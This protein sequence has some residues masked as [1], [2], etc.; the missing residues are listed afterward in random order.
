MAVTYG[1]E[2]RV[3][4]GN[5]A[6]TQHNRPFTGL[7][8][9]GSTFLS[10]FQVSESP[11]ALLDSVTF[12]DTPGV[13]SGDKQRLGR[14]YDFV[15]VCQWFAERADMILILFDAHKLDISD[16]LKD[17]INVIRPHEDKIKIVLNK[18]DQISSQEL[19]RVYGALMWSL[20]KTIYTPEVVR[21]YIGSFWM[22]KSPVGNGEQAALLE[23][24]QTDL[25][26][27]LHGLPKDSAI[28]K[29]NEMI[30]RA[31]QIRVHAI[32]LGQLRYQ[33]PS[34]WGKANKQNKMIA[35]MKEEMYKVQQEFQFPICDLPDP[36]QYQD[37]LRNMDISS[38]PKISTKYTDMLNE[39]ITSDL[40]NLLQAFV[41]IHNTLGQVP[42][43]PFDN[44]ALKP[45]TSAQSSYEKSAK[46]FYTLHPDAGK[47]SG[48]KAREVLE[49]SGLGSDELAKIWAEADEDQDGQ[50]TEAEFCKAMELLNLKSL[51]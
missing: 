34:F 40:P 35:N 14:S 24:E 3:I 1:E 43:N 27:H 30:K 23:A 2:E 31:K 50:L 51:A 32:I 44:S 17:V 49:K 16:E 18:A 37:I 45:T 29:I 4:P 41:R 36:G 38:L 28:R 42:H 9:F 33:M 47:I 7:S 12:I 21:V 19:M 15:K 48:D 25:L 46:L 39:A 8:Q 22:P 13:L 6:A 10:K 20:G 11:A 26:K 5:A